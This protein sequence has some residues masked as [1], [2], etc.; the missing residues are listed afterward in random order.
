[1][2]S[3]FASC[4]GRIGQEVVVVEVVATVVRP[5]AGFDKA[6]SATELWKAGIQAEITSHMDGAALGELRSSN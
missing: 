4:E 2:A 5:G 6:V 3:V 1:M